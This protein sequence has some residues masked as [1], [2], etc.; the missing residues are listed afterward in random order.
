MKI[1]RTLYSSLNLD[2]FKE[3]IEF[4]HSN[5]WFRRARYKITKSEINYNIFQKIFS[6]QK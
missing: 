3:F 5:S 2:E 4:M 1:K 6:C